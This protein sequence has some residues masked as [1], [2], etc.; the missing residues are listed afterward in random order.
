MCFLLH[1]RSFEQKEYEDYIL[2]SFQPYSV[3][4]PKSQFNSLSTNGTLVFKFPFLKV[5]NRLRTLISSRRQSKELYTWEHLMLGGFSGA[6]AA[7]VTMPLDVVKTTIQCG[8]RH[9]TTRAALVSIYQDKGMKGLFAGMTPRVTQVAVSSA[10]FFAMFEFWKMTLKPATFVF[11][12][13]SFN[14]DFMFLEKERHRINFLVQ[15]SSRRNEPRFGSDCYPLSEPKKHHLSRHVFTQMSR[16]LFHPMSA[17]RKN[18]LFFVAHLSLR[19]TL[20]L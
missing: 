1:R 12:L 18:L 16:S 14:H 10:A 17:N 6:V 13:F 11:F 9:G 4:S 20:L 7:I 3:M 2:D 15:R 19:F 5:K 8:T